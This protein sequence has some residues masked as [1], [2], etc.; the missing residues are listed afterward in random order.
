VYTACPPGWG[1]PFGDTILIGEMAVQ[2]GWNV[3]YEVE[4]GVFR[5]SAASQ[6]IARK[7]DLRPVREFL[8]LQGRYANVVEDTI[9]ELQGWITARWQRYLVRADFV[10]GIP[11]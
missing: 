6:A 10:I 11:G 7:G 8:A 3:L 2:T 5:L 1:F 9:Q 4:N